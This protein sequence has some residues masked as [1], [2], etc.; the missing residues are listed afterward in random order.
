MDAETIILCSVLIG[1]QNPFIEQ[2]PIYRH[3][4]RSESI[5][6]E[7]LKP[8]RAQADA[9]LSGCGET[10]CTTS[11]PSTSVAISGGLSQ[12]VVS[13]MLDTFFLR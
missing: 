7:R 12:G 9:C 4:R 3:N 5:S 13:L 1:V 6:T 2:N 11:A 10:D 8:W